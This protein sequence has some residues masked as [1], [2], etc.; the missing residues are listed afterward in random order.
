MKRGELDDLVAFATIARTRSFTRA[1]AE[2]SL[3]PSALSHA[4]RGLEVRLGVRLL[5]RTTRSVA[6]T[7]AGERLL[8][9]LEPALR[10]V[11]TG[12]EALNDWRGEP[13]GPIRITTSQFAAHTVLA[14]M[15]LSFCSRIRRF[16]LRSVLIPDWRILFAM[17]SMQEFGGARRSTRIWLRS[18]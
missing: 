6:P 1:A 7:Q 18:A 3:S 13:S 9:S 14:P 11:E 2:L 17:A 8:C 4:I 16:P 5:A 12:L 10:A 15:L